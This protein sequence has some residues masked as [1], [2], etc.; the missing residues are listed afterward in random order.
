MLMA[1]GAEEAMKS[2]YHP[3]PLKVKDICYCIMIQ[4]GE[5]KNNSN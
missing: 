2:Y 5:V 4:F 1:R 3:L